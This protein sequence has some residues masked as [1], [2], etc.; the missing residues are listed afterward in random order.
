MNS[1]EYL[2]LV[3]EVSELKALLAEL[4]SANV[5]NRMGLESRLKAAESA[6]VGQGSLQL[7]KK[8]KLTFRGRPVFGSKGIA[9]EF[10]AKAAVYFAEA[11][12]AAAAALAE[13]LRYMGP[14][15]DKEKTSF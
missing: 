2:Y 15:P 6:L 10:G 12:A 14:I 3:S 7:V 4:P 8:A 13:N 5:I 1:Q 11:F 9:A